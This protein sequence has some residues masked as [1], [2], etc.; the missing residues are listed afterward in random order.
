VNRRALWGSLIGFVLVVAALLG[1]NLATENHPV[2][3]L[4]LQGGVSVILQPT[5]EVGEEDL[6]TVRSLIRDELES[7]GIA[8]PDVRVEGTNIVVDLPGVKDQAQA[9]EAVD[10]AGIVTLRPVLLCQPGAISPE[11]L[12]SLPAG[13]EAL[14]TADG[15]QTCLV[16]PPGG[17]GEVFARGS[18]SPQIDQSSGRWL[19]T[20]DLRED[21][22]AVWN[23]LAAA[24]FAGDVS[25]PSRQLAIVLDDV[26]QSAPTVN[27][28]S[29]S[30]GVEITGAFTEEEVR[31][32]ARVLNRGAFPV[33][34]EAQRVETVSPTAG[35]DSLRAA[36]I[37]GIVGVAVM[38]LGLVLYYRRIAVVV[39]AGL[40]VWGATVFS[41]A[42]FVSQATNYAL[43]LAGVTGIIV[44]IGVTIDSYIVLF[45][46]LKD[47]VRAGRTPRNA[48]PRSFQST[49]RTILTADLVSVMASAIL[50]WL[51]VGSVK[52]FALYLGLTTLADLVVC[53]LFTRP[54]VILMASRHRDGRL[55]GL[56]ARA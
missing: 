26:V 55:V 56:G 12:E 34:V 30:T 17:T 10:V 32:L 41:L 8:E 46:R 28:P 38:L 52:G 49:W 3:G 42:A 14:P 45:E 44:A 39:V 19:V 27:Q 54:A 23:A 6:D 31:S 1:V 43:S 33:D 25:C 7:L 24:C 36:I 18:A 22:Q 9:L 51:S 11:L 2:L 4:D 37:A 35:S 5:E 40:V 13:Q 48:A 47:E 20:V 53:Y 16:G 21:G 29:F 15:L 50:F